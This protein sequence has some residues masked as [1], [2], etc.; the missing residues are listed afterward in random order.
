M[1]TDEVEARHYGL[2]FFARGGDLRDE[3]PETKAAEAGAA[4]GQAGDVACFGLPAEHGEEEGFAVY[5]G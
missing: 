4:G 5:G 3:E 1:F 2:F